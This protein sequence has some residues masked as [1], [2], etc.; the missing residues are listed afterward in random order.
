MKRTWSLFLVL[1]MLLTLLAGCGAA[2]TETEAETT[3]PQETAASEPP[4]TV[5]DSPSAEPP[6]APSES[7]AAE[8]PE[9][10]DAVSESPEE[11]AEPVYDSVKDMYTDMSRRT[12]EE[13]KALCDEVG[14]VI[15]Y[16]LDTDETLVLW[17]TFSAYVW[18]GLINSYEETPTLPD[19]EAATGVTVDFI[20]T[21]DVTATEQF[22]LMIVSGSYPD[23]FSLDSYSGGVESAYENDIC[24]DL[25]DL[26]AEHAPNYMA[27]VYNFLDEYTLKS[28]YTEEGQIL[29]IWG[30]M[31]NVISEQGL[32]LRTD[33]LEEF[34][35][36]TPTT[37]DELY[38]YLVAAKSTYDCTYPLFIDNSGVLEGFTGAFG[39]PGMTL[40][41]ADLGMMLDGNTVV[42]SIQEDSFRSY[43]EGFS[44]FYTEGLIKDDFYSEGYG[45]DY[46]NAYIIDDDCAVSTIRS[47]KFTTLANSA[48]ASSFQFEAMAPLVLE[49]G[50]TYKFRMKT[51]LTGMGNLSISSTCADPELAL[52]FLNWFYTWD[53]YLLCNYGQEGVAYEMDADGQP[54]Y[55]EF[56]LNNPDGYNPLNIRN[57]Y[58][59]PAFITY[60]NATAL[61]YTYADEELEAF[62]VWNNNGT[63]E[64]SMPT[65]NLTSDEAAEY[66][67]IAADVATYASEAAMK[68]MTGEETITDEGWDAYV[69]QLK[70][71]GIDRAVEIYQTVYDRMYK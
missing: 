69:A 25:T 27:V 39:T 29:R 66:A 1:T 10:S 34:G 53:G 11:A 71:L 42:A 61:F 67:Q 33:W 22:N 41:S 6:A 51:G 32:A 48:A 52:E 63:D 68:W 20:E 36:E 7:P 19:I 26:V 60:G 18:G 59:N 30:L 56:I 37:V 28:I 12:N 9:E 23:L 16:P 8:S 58:T 50:D 15:S 3:E 17:K 31:S 40:G 62:E 13:M 35:M 45:P 24:I 64:C 54:Q 49:E 4:E 14:E 47:D 21:S 46:I 57:L 44:R 65:L 5:E 43:C 38:D 2:G 55:T 70:N